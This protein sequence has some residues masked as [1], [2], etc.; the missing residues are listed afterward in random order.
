[1]SESWPLSVG[2]A[3]ECMVE[4]SHDSYGNL[5]TLANFNYV[6]FSNCQINTSG[7]GNLN[8]DYDV[9]NN[10]SGQLMAGVGPISNGT[11]YRVTWYRAS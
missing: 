7:I 1:M 6:A 11:D 3:G 4:R 9:L 8:H 5:I 2:D 10:N